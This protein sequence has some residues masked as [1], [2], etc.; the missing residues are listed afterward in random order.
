VG[1][2]NNA[3]TSRDVTGY[4]Q[5]V[6][7]NHLERLI[8]AEAS[9]LSSLVVNEAVFESER[10]VVKEEYRQGVLAQPYGRLFSVFMPATIYQEHPY[11]RTTIGS[12]EDLD[13]ATLEDVLRF[14][15]TYYRPDNAILMA[16]GSTSIWR[17]SPI[18]TG[19]CLR[20]MCRNPS[21]P[22]RAKPPS[23]RPMCRCRLWFWPGR[24]CPMPT[25]TGSP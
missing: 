25:R 19:H 3:F 5:T 10:D 16:A 21:R 1:G 24:P 12:I 20:T 4:F 18:P 7:A 6:P 9:R 15:A 17:P 13:A 14:H 22:A 2:N 11:R 23:M 8:F